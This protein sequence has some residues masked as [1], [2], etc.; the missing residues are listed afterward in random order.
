MTASASISNLCLD[1]GRRGIDDRDPG[2][3][4]AGEDLVAQRRARCCEIGPG[5][6]AFADTG[7][8]R[9][10]HGHGPAVIHQMTH[11]VGEVELPLR[12]VG[13]EVRESAPER[14]RGEDVHRGVD[15]PDRELLRRGV[16]RLDDRPQPPRRVAHDTAVVTRVGGLER[17]DGRGGALGAMGLGESVELVAGQERGVARED[18]DV[19]L[20]ALERRVRR[21]DRVA[22]A[23]GRLLHREDDAVRERALEL[24]DGGRRRDD[25]EGLR[26]EPP[27]GA[28]DPVDQA[29]AEDRMQVLGPPRPHAG[30]EP[31]G[32]HDRCEGGARHEEVMAGAGG[33]EPPVTGPKPAALPLG[34]APLPA[35]IWP[36]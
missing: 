24:R 26:V 20:E 36:G 27:R 5:V 13:V 11:R 35:S 16:A 29:P 12:V 3:H 14:V 28:D 2:L 4:V 17:E 18:E 32:H 33:F 8:G 15:L 23:A 25:H 30:A 1:P 10:V 6:H 21:G 34:Y 31:C 9:T 19:P 7:V 22:G